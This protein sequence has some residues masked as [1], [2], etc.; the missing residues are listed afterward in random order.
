MSDAPEPAARRV[1]RLSRASLEVAAFLA[2][3]V[4]FGLSSMYSLYRS[5]YPNSLNVAT[6]S[7]TGSLLVA[8]GTVSVAVSLPL[9]QPEATRA[10]PANVAVR[11]THDLLFVRTSTPC[12]NRTTLRRAVQRGHGV[13]RPRPYWVLG[14]LPRRELAAGARLPERGLSGRALSQHPPIVERLSRRPCG[15][16]QIVT[17][18]GGERS[19]RH[20]RV[21][22]AYPHVPGGSH[23]G[24]S[25]PRRPGGRP[26]SLCSLRAMW[27]SSAAGSSG[28]TST[29]GWLRS[30]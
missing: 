27:S 11:A 20:V 7:V 12:V 8:E 4:T 3:I 29:T 26:G 18:L 10:I 1:F 23:H 24:R 21:A 13:P 16:Y 15:S 28:S 19:P 2:S 9:E 17:F 5:S 6:E 30:S 22:S 14:P 25:R